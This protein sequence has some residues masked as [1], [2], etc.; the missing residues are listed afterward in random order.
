MCV[1]PNAAVTA[2]IVEGVGKE[3]VDELVGLVDMLA[4][5]QQLVDSLQAIIDDPALLA[6]VAE[7]EVKEIQEL[8]QNFE[9]QL[10][11]AGWD[12]ANEAGENLGRITAKIVALVGGAAGAAKVTKSIVKGIKDTIAKKVDDVGSSTKS[13][14]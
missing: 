14:M 9:E 4:N 6:E 3:A 1:R 12:G 11:I 10:E 5:P 7:N 8:L 13:I 2:G